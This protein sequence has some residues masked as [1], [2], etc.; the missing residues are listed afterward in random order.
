MASTIKVDN[1]QNQPGTNIVNKCGTTTTIGA[2]AGET[3]NVCAATVNLGRSGGTVNLTCGATQSGFG[4]TGTVDW[5]T[6]SIKTTTFTAANGEGYFANTTSGG[7]TMNLPAGSA[8]N[9]VSVVDYTNT[10]ASNNLTVTPNGSEKIGGANASATLSTE[11]QSVTFVYV[12]ATEGWKN[13][14]DSTSNV[15]GE[16]FLTATVSGACNT[17]TTAPCCANIKVATFLG[18]GT[19]CVSSISTTAAENTVGYMVV[20][21]G[22]AGG[23]GSGGGGGAGGYREGRNVPVDNFTASPLVANSPTNAVTVTATAYPITVGAGG[24]GAPSNCVGGSGA[25]SIF[26]T[27]TS[28]GGGGGGAYSA[29]PQSHGADGGSGGGGGYVFPGAPG[30]HATP[31]DYKG[32]GN[33]PPVS[34]SQGNTGGKGFTNYTPS[35]LTNTGGG[36]GATAVGTCGSGSGSGVGGAGATSSINATPTVRAGGGGGGTAVN[37]S[38]GAGGPGGGGAGGNLP[39]GAGTAGTVNTGGGAGGNSDKPGPDGIG[40]GSGIVIIRYKFQ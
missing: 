40:G 13:V 26:S 8:G 1:V 37:G 6:G 22:G 25:N 5:Q 3:V 20:A 28:A 30:P 36:G 2:G 39:A 11:G 19:F 29:P 34:P 23:A 33:T 12:D 15:I 16:T 21:G 27:V 31:D 24:A 32:V 35:G 7:F 17:L 4:R 10:F 18:P 9:I 14:Q 38:G